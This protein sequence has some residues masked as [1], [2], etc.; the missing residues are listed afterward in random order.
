MLDSPETFIARRP[1]ADGARTITPGRVERLISHAFLGFFALCL[2]V[3]LLQTVYPVAQT[4]YPSF[5]T[6]VPPLEERRE[7]SPFPSLSLLSRANGAFATA[8]NKWFDD[9]VGL[10]D[11]FI[12]SKNQI[13]YSLFH[14]SRKVYVGYDGWLF[15]HPDHPPM[16][17]ERLVALKES[18]AVLAQRLHD[19]G[20]QL[21]VVGYPAKSEIYPEKA[22]PQLV[23]RS[24]GGNYDRF[25][26]FMAS[27][28][29]LIFID[30]EEI[31]K[32]EK[33][34]TSENLYAKTDLHATHVGQLPVV[35][36]IIARIAQA[37]GRPQIRWNEKFTLVHGSMGGPGTGS[38]FL[39]LLTPAILESQYPYYKEQYAIGGQEPDGHWV[40]PNSNL[41]L[42]DDG[43]RRPFDWE[44][45]SLPELCNQRLPGTVL[46]G[47][48]FSD[49]YWS[50]GLQRYFCF[51]RRA[52]DPITRL[53]L[54]YET[55]P[56][57]TKYF[58]FQYYEPTLE[59]PVIK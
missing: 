19:K 51:I 20:V 46:F 17:A 15:D 2:V 18:F 38:R 36:E 35:K 56:A 6:I 28:S 30:A 9:R 4:I 55:M 12:R 47:N 3:P 33:S 54:F 7:L 34:I 48:S 59:L 37:E 49:F 58:I 39:S 10:R 43:N 57:D 26:Q 22:P 44:F 45:V 40:I 53:T 27:R 8:L 41:A 32:R 21:V 1:A 50:L 14:T 42:A 23:R 25:R 16:D 24:V 5:E 29:D 52:R 31:L 11:L 13:D